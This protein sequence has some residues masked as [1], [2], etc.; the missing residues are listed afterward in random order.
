MDNN[1]VEIKAELMLVGVLAHGCPC[2]R[3]EERVQ[4]EG[5]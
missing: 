5:V 2:S 3:K 1:M 4:R